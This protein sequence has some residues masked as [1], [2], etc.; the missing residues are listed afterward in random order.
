MSAKMRAKLRIGAIVKHSENS[1]TLRFFGVSKSTN[2]PV[3]GSDE[4]N[5][6]A[7]FSPSV[8]LELQL[9]NPELLGKFNVGDTFYVDFTPVEAK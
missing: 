6:F 7:K 1:E 8:N 9:A 2:Y 4:D 3:D 5:T